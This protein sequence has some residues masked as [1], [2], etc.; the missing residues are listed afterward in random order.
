MQAH[1]KRVIKSLIHTVDN[2]NKTEKTRLLV[3]GKIIQV[4]PRAAATAGS[5]GRSNCMQL[6]PYCCHR[7]AVFQ[8]A[9][10]PGEEG[11]QLHLMGIVT[12]IDRCCQCNSSTLSNYDDGHHQQKTQIFSW[13]TLIENCHHHHPHPHCCSAEQENSIPK[14]RGLQQRIAIVTYDHPGHAFRQK[15]DLTKIFEIVL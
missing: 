3:H 6:Y 8:E 11:L 2:K 4:V 12:V 10:H 14:N 9:N 1:C 5:R 7:E 13:I 15:A